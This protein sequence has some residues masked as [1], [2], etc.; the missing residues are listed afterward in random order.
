MDIFQIDFGLKWYRF[1]HLDRQL[2]QPIS[3]KIGNMSAGSSQIHYKSNE[4][5]ILNK[6]SW[7]EPPR[8]DAWWQ[9]RHLSSSSSPLYT[10]CSPSTLLGHNEV[11]TKFNIIWSMCRWSSSKGDTVSLVALTSERRSHDR[12]PAEVDLSWSSSHRYPFRSLLTP[13]RHG[14]AVTSFNVIC[15]RC[16]WTSSEGDRGPS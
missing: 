14:V 7:W 3:P 10:F 13:L 16:R 5:T 8:R 12:S 2:H 4:I 9:R 1:H 15:S 6:L 11:V